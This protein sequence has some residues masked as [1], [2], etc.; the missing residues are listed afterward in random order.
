[1]NSKGFLDAFYK[2]TWADKQKAAKVPSCGIDTTSGMS[3]TSMD[4][5]SFPK[6]TVSSTACGTRPA[7][8]WVTAAVTTS[9]KYLNKKSFGNI[10]QWF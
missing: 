2:E 6:V 9:W 4:V 10:D 3:T 8:G 5:R 7:I 1:M